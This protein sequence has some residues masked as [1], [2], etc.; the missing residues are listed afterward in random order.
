MNLSTVSE[1][2]LRAIQRFILCFDNSHSIDIGNK[3][4]MIK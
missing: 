1:K 3:K 2:H 4:T